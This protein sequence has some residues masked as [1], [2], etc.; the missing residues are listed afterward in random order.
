[1]NAVSFVHIVIHY[2]ASNKVLKKSYILCVFYF[3]NS[4]KLIFLIISIINESSKLL[5]AKKEM[6]S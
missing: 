6:Q 4:P 5:I 3:Y 1:M 2:T